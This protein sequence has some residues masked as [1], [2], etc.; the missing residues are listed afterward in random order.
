[1]I[2]TNV[3][4]RCDWFA[5]TISSFSSLC[6]GLPAPEAANNPLRYKFS[7]SPLGVLRAA[8]NSAQFLHNND[9]VQVDGADLLVNAQP[10]GCFPTLALEHLPN[11]DSL[12]YGDIYGIA[13]SSCTQ[14]YR[15][16]LRYAG[17]SRL[18]EDFR[19]IGL[20]T[21][22]AAQERDDVPATWG[23]LMVMVHQSARYILYFYPGIFY[24]F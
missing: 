2:N 3:F 19:K 20:T 15:G 14:I 7:W 11:R 1:M 6:G 22:D 21:V 13:D 4:F 5:G 18:M 17:W 24:F 16:T 23:E 10:T 12:P 8:Q 9:V